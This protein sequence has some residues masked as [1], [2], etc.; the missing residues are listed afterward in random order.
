M[1]LYQFTLQVFSSQL[2]ST[3]ELHVLDRAQQRAT[4]II[5]G[6]KHLSLEVRLSELGQFSLENRR[7]REDLINVQKGL[8]LKGPKKDTAKKMEPGSF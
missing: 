7:L 8:N 4:K 1:I 5:R 2:P 3:R 6:L